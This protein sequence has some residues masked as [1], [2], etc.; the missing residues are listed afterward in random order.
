[1]T[2]LTHMS[3]YG[4][5]PAPVPVLVY[6][7]LALSSRCVSRVK[8]ASA[9]ACATCASPKK[10]IRSPRFIRIEPRY[11]LVALVAGSRSLTKVTRVV[12]AP[13]HQSRVRRASDAWKLPP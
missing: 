11:A 4:S 1:M 2:E 7:R 13:I 8:A 5:M 10:A 3:R 9:V 12:Y 6:R